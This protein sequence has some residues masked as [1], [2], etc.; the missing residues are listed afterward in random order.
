MDNPSDNQER[1]VL[2]LGAG[3]TK[4]FLPDAPLMV[5][6][7]D[8]EALAEKFLRFPHASRILNWERS[9]EPDGNINIERLMTRLDGRMPYDF[10]QG[11]DEELGMLLTEV[12]NS[13][14]QRLHTARQGETH[15]DDLVS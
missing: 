13:F 3:F 8:G 12:K 10:D 1:K 6:D 15:S 11:A 5:D 2:V 4:A 14:M 9:Q 7:Y